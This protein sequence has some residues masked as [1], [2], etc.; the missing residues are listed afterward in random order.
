MLNRTIVA[1]F[2]ATSA[3]AF[4]VPS[5]HAEGPRCKLPQPVSE[6]SERGSARP[7]GTVDLPPPGDGKTEL[8]RTVRA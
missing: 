4:G 6:Q 1:A 8:P 3:G 7:L 5:A 2:L